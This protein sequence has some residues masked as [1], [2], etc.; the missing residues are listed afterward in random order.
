MYTH[1]VDPITKSRQTIHSRGGKNILKTYLKHQKDGTQSK[2][3]KKSLKALKSVYKSTRSSLDTEGIIFNKITYDSSGGKKKFKYDIVVFSADYDGCWDILFGPIKRLLNKRVKSY[4][5]AQDK[6][7]SNIKDFLEMAPKHILM[8]GSARQ[9]IEMDKYNREIHCD[10]HKKLGI[11]Y[12][13]HE[14]YC[15]R[16]FTTICD[17]NKWTLLRFLYPDISKATYS[18][19]AN[20]ILLDIESRKKGNLENKNLV[21]S[22][23]SLFTGKKLISKSEIIFSQI[24]IL[25][26]LYP[27]KKILL[28]FYDDDSSGTMFN[29]L[30]IKLKKKKIPSNITIKLYRFNWFNILNKGDELTEIK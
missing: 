20:N 12:K 30:I 28:V 24:N 27:K 6:L 10:Q 22:N 1:I 14:G 13:K 25:N 8:V 21:W 2:S 5:Y 19:V 29:G 3:N 18:K 26:I 7:V 15:L 23:P 11:H 17:D 9:S 4:L 16:D